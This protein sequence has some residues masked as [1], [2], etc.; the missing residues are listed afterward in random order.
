MK[1]V[2]PLEALRRAR[3]P[4]GGARRALVVGGWTLALAGL[5]DDLALDLERRFGPFLREAPDANAETVLRVDLVDGGDASWLPPPAP[6]ETYRI[7]ARVVDGRA[8]LGSYHFLAGPDVDRGEGA[9]RAIVTR[10][11]AEPVGRV[12]EN[13]LRM[14]LSRVV[15][16]RGGVPFHAAGVLREDGAHLLVGPSNAGK[17]TAVALSRPCVALGD[18]YGFAVP[19]P[20][21]WVTAAVPFDNRE[22]VEEAPPPGWL[23]LVGVWR[24]FQAEESRLE[25]PAAMARDLSILATAAAPWSMPDLGERLMEN[26]ARLGREVP[27][28]HLHFDRSGDFWDRIAPR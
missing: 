21:G 5:D 4:F 20:G 12:V 16:L 10:T 17:T 19:G 2:D 18:D 22:A 15:V 6:G 9:W 13:V 23:P 8:V 11:P 27:Y 26:V 28:G 24:L 25:T 14:L 3:M 1:D 7:E